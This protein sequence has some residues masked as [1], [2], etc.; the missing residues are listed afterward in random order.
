M[1][2]QRAAEACQLLA[3]RLAIPIHWG[4]LYPLALHHFSSTFLTQPPQ[5]FVQFMLRTAPQVQVRVLQPGQHY[6]APSG[7]PFAASPA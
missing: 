6:D 1:D 5:M 7:A 2:P 3:P 4:T